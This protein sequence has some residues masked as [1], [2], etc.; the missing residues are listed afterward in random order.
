MCNKYLYKKR[1]RKKN[2]LIQPQAKSYPECGYKREREKILGKYLGKTEGK[3]KKKKV[4][5]NK[6]EKKNQDSEEGGGGG[7]G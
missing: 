1:E 7:G 5:Q 2:L 3:K 6:K 4:D